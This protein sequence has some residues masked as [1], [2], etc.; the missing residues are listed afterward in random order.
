MKRTLSKVCIAIVVFVALAMPCAGADGTQVTII[1][2][3]TINGQ[4]SPVG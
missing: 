1:Y 3:N 4:V 2:S